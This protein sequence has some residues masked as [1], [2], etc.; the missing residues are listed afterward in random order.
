MKNEN[1]LAS[2][3][4][5]KEKQNMPEKERKAQI[6]ITLQKCSLICHPSKSIHAWAPETEKE[7]NIKKKE[8]EKKHLQSSRH[9]S[10][11]KRKSWRKG[12]TKFF[13]KK[14]KWR[15]EKAI[16]D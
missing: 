14:M 8:K 11:R 6:I 13:V 15:H 16:F 2:K 10:S 5:E 1:N 9:A 3:L 12:E 4:H 7:N